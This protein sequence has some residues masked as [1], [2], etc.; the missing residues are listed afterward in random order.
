MYSTGFS[1]SYVNFLQMMPEEFAVRPD[2]FDFI[3]NFYDR[4]NNL[5]DSVVRLENV[6]FSG[7]NM[8]VVGTD[9]VLKGNVEF[10]LS[11]C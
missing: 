10:T 3:V 5:A 8:V 2:Q 7:S 9:N 4:S 1:P 11:I 6:E